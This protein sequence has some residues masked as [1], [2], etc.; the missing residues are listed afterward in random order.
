MTALHSLNCLCF[1]CEDASACAAWSAV[2]PAGVTLEDHLQT[3]GLC[4]ICGAQ[5]KI[6]GIT[7]DDRLIGSCHDAF[8]LAQ[9]LA[10]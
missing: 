7:T 10:Y 5:I 4:P 2:P 8:T 3:T 9:W 1:N 6:I